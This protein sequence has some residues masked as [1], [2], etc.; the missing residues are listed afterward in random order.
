MTIEITDSIPG[1][2]THGWESNTNPNLTV[3][4]YSIP[5]TARERRESNF[6][7][8]KV[9]WS[10]ERGWLNVR[11]PHDGAW[12]SIPAKEAPRG[13]VRLANEAKGR[14]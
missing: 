7:P 12:Y 3:N 10:R 14:R 9:A 8:P 4:A 13:Y 5:N 2:P 11:D 6:W 1:I